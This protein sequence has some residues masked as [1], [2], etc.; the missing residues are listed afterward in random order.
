MT[1]EIPAPLQQTEHVTIFIIECLNSR[2]EVRNI[3]SLIQA[4]PEGKKR[5]KFTSMTNGTLPMTDDQRRI[6]WKGTFDRR[7]A[8]KVTKFCVF[9]RVEHCKFNI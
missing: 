7:V 6:V 4:L 5:K 2:F 9:N 1:D 3:V 8:H